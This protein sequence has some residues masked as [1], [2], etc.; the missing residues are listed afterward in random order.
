MNFIKKHR[1]KII[2]ALIAIVIVGIVTGGTYLYLEGRNRII[3]QPENEY[4][5]AIYIQAQNNIGIGIM[6]AVRENG[7]FIITN[8]DDKIILIEKPKE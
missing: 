4:N 8:G 1:E 7:E 6:N 3:W 5:Q 2:G